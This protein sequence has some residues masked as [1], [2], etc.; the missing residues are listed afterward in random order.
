M[1]APDCLNAC[2][3]QRVRME[4][5]AERIERLR[6]LLRQLSRET[7]ADVASGSRDDL[8][9]GHITVRGKPGPEYQT[10]RRSLQE[11]EEKYLRMECQLLGLILTAEDY[12]ETVEQSR[13]RLVLR[14][15][16]IDGLTWEHIGRKTDRT[17]RGCR[18]MVER[19]FAS[20]SRHCP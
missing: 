19:Y 4:E 8:S 17:E 1:G 10:V 11:A 14:L 7:V 6:R 5:Q 16:F 2:L 13:L 18:A 3:M 15:R 20:G 9:Y 12:L